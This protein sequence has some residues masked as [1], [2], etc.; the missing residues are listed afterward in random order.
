MRGI[1]VVKFLQELWSHVSEI[2]L[3]NLSDKVMFCV[4][5]DIFLKIPSVY[6]Y[7]YMRRK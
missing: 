3:H 4:T 6:K 2:P 5:Q 1:S 7:W